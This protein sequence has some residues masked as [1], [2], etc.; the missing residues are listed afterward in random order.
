MPV[1][2]HPSRLL[3]CLAVAA[4]AGGC[5]GVQGTVTLPTA[6]SDT[7]DSRA[8]DTVPRALPPNLLLLLLD[9]VGLDKVALA[10]I[11]PHPA[12]TPHLDA[13]AASGL[14]FSQ[15]WAYPTCSP[16]RASLLTGRH[17]ERHG[18]GI[19]IAS[20]VE[21]YR[22]PD[23]EVT[24]PELLAR[25]EVPYTSFAVGKWHLDG[26]L[27]PGAARSPL[28]HGFAHHRGALGNPNE[29]IPVVPASH[30]DGAWQYARDGAL[31]WRTDFMATVEVDDA[32][33]LIDA[34]PEPWFGYVAFHAVHKPWDVPPAPLPGSEIDPEAPEA[35]RY[36]AVLRAVDAE[37]G[38]LL[39]SLDPD[40]A[41]RTWVVL[42]SD[43]GTPTQVI[44][45]PFDAR[46]AK[47][48]VF[49]GGVR[50]PLV[51]RGPGARTGREP[52][53]VS[54]ADLMPTFL[55]L[56]GVPE[57]ARVD[58]DGAPLVFDGRSL[59]PWL[60]AA[61]GDVAAGD[62]ILYTESFEPNGY[63]FDPA[64]PDAL[65]RDVRVAVRD[66]AFK[67]AVQAPFGPM[68]FDLRDAAFDE[69]VPQTDPAFLQAHA[70][71][72]TRLREALEAHPWVPGRPPGPLAGTGAPTP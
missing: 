30:P 15:T 7:A 47:G 39:D 55:D 67:L 61:R 57:A 19:W 27:D 51:V 41:A 22:F 68:V 18:L 44:E 28:R 40:V 17:P 66:A 20:N 38:R 49:E 59:V 56:A 72:L 12:P 42:A 29:A 23:D 6:D 5:D 14:T 13:L 48:T 43:N 21:G 64:A 34:T 33:E 35:A 45:P 1:R 63:V 60:G 24:I 16:A 37:I 9:D 3:R 50:V 31:S 26:F 4:V 58:G 54:L 8:V 62:R 36:D 11:A 2:V 52:A 46:R 69:G 65:P 25:A 10:G 71:E 70:P 32:L 53:L